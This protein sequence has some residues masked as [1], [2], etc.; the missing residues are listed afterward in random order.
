MFITKLKHTF[1]KIMVQK[2]CLSFVIILNS[3]T[4]SG[5]FFLL[6]VFE[7][8]PVLTPWLVQ[9]PEVADTLSLARPAD[10]GVPDMKRFLK[11]A[12]PPP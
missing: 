3:N 5:R 6:S 4:L 12:P 10:H 2:V 7:F 1:L 9:S 8:C 11:N